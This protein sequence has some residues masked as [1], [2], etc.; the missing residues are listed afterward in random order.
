[1]RKILLL[2]LVLL[3]SAAAFGCTGK[4]ELELPQSLEFNYLSQSEMVSC[5]EYF[6][7]MGDDMHIRI[8][9][10][11][12]TAFAD[13][14]AIEATMQKSIKLL[15]GDD[16]SFYYSELETAERYG[17]GTGFRVYRHFAATGKKELVYKDTLVSNTEGF[18]GLEEM[19][20]IDRLTTGYY[21]D[22]MTRFVIIG[23]KA[24]PEYKLAE[25]LRAAAADTFPE[26]K[27]PD[28]QFRFAVSGGVCFF[29]D[30]FGTL[31]RYQAEK[32]DVEKLPFENV[33]AFF[34]AGERLFVAPEN[35]ADLEV[36]D[37]SGEPLGSVNMHNIPFVG[38]LVIDGTDIFLQTADFEIVHVDVDLVLTR[39]GLYSYDNRWTIKEGVLY[40][41]LDGKV[42]AFGREP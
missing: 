28:S 11:T 16:T 31:Y 29:A 9:S 33:Y 22:R 38:N 25:K 35:G 34:T 12:G 4:T 20:S 1:M 24:I 18:L 15:G 3:I 39:T 19:L 26:M 6:I 13:D 41:Y 42:L 30:S 27:L 36:F 10:E 37:I 21:M 8:L 17:K 40:R 23:N 2:F 32:G 14:N 5:G 7:C